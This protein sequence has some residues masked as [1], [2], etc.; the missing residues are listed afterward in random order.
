MITNIPSLNSYL[1]QNI[2]PIVADWP[3]QL[4]IRKI[5]THLKIQQSVTNIPQNFK[6]FHSI[7]GSFHVALNSQETVLMINYEFFNQLFYF[8]FGDKKILAK[9]PKPW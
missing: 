7:I 5:I 3:G 8:V 9:K 4:F 1:N 2:I 6:N